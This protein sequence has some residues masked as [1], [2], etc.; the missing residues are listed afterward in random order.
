MIRVIQPSIRQLSETEV[1][2]LMSRSYQGPAP[3]CEIMD[4]GR[5]LADV[6]IDTEPG[7]RDIER[8]GLR[9]GVGLLHTLLKPANCIP[10]ME[11]A[12][13]SRTP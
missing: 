12:A 5:K 6:I 8:L 7:L 11:P 1:A 9:I 2:A 10:T 3:F 13:P 4:A